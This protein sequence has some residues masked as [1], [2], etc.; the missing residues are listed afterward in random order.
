M[1]P[2]DPIEKRLRETPLPGLKH[3]LHRDSLKQSLLA[4]MLKETAMNEKTTSPS[5]ATENPTTPKRR[6]FASR[7]V[8]TSAAVAVVSLVVIGWQSLNRST[9][10]FEFF[11]E[12]KRA[13][14]E[15]PGGLVASKAEP[16]Q[17]PHLYDSAPDDIHTLDTDPSPAS[18]SRPVPIPGQAKQPV[19]GQRWN[20]IEPSGGKLGGGAL[21]GGALG[22]ALGGA[23]GG[24]PS[25][26]GPT[27]HMGAP[28]HP[29]AFDHYAP[30]TDNPFHKPAQKPLSTFSIDVD[31]ASYTNVRRFLTQER[32]L[33]PADAVRIEEMIN[34]FPYDDP[35]PNDGKPVAIKTDVG[36]CPWNADHKLVRIGLRAKSVS[37]EDSP[38]R[39]LVFLLDTSGSMSPA[40]RLP[41]LKKGLTL[42][43]GTLRPQ[44][45]VGIVAYAGS[46][47]LVLPSTSGDDKEK[48]LAALN[49]LES[50]GSTN[51]GE[52]IVLAY[53]LAQESFLKDGVNRVILGTDGDFNVGVTSQGDLV[54][55]IEEKRK[56]GILL[57]IL[58]F[59]HGNLK[60]ATM[61]KLA[62]HGNG[63]YAYI[64]NLEEAHRIFVEQGAALQVVAYDVKVQVEFN[65]ARVAAYRLVGY[66]NR[67]MKDRDFNDDTKDAGDMGSGHTVTALYEIVPTGKNVEGVDPLRYQTPAPK[68][69]PPKEALPDAAKSSELMMV[70]VRYKDPGAEVSKLLM[71]PVEDIHRPLAETSVDF[72]FAAAVAEFALI[73]RDSPYKGTAN[74]NNVI[75]QSR[76][77][78]GPDFH[79]HRAAFV[80]MVQAAQ[81]LKR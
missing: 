15:K 64:D 5:P 67:L 50:G 78:I 13:Y 20:G 45:R 55:L 17:R 59:G 21:G 22:G 18:P 81:Q 23:G 58:G 41:L 72:R 62:H 75:E 44:D 25:A 76:G 60:D 32:Q 24:L 36:P 39:N 28:S 10:S 49:R 12:K 30:R 26:G 65:P 29:M 70:K 48:I 53:K 14:A 33:P 11:P 43:V 3:G 8:G 31:T 61:E 54:R 1:Q 69:D 80:S 52:G 79:G 9:E 2:P 42:L 47:G 6:R 40:D 4:E 51:G 27:I 73:L 63:H 57:S 56:N 35:R 68:V 77:S 66:E 74:F 34:Y 37:A 46:A 19:Q 16:R 7:W 71:K 38:P